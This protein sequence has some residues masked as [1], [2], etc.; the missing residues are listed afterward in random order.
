MTEAPSVE[1]KNAR[2]PLEWRAHEYVHVEKTQDWYWAL[3][4]LAVAGAVT[5]LLF[6]NVLFAIFILIASFVL[7]LFAA[8]KPDLVS[9]SLTQRGVRINDKLYQFS[10]FDSFAIDEISSSHTPKL[11]LESNKHFMPHIVIPLEGVHADDVHDFLK[12]FLHE[13]H[14]MEPL[15]HRVM[16]WL[17]F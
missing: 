1:R 16:E 8:R 12:H 4:L 9:F 13:K 2:G 3:G 17:G 15:A 7:A 14:H 10:T 11:I 5:S 6:N